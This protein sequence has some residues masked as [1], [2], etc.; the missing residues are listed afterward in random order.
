MET[1]IYICT[2]FSDWKDLQALYKLSKWFSEHAICT[3]SSQE[4]LY[5][6]WLYARNSS[7]NIYTAS[8]A[9]KQVLIKVNCKEEKWSNGLVFFIIAFHTISYAWK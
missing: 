2:T 9:M 5:V 3:L 8:L 7:N 4:T 6:D 1:I